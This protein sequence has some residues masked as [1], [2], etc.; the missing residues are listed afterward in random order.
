MLDFWFFVFPKEIQAW[1][2]RFRPAPATSLLPAVMIWGVAVWSLLVKNVAGKGRSMKRNFHEH[3]F[4]F[5]FHKIFIC[6]FHIAVRSTKGSNGTATSG[7]EWKWQWKMKNKYKM[8]VD[9]FPTFTSLFLS[10]L[11][12]FSSS[13]Q[14]SEENEKGKRK[15][16]KK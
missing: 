3:N 4:V 2:S 1:G 9:F 12:L 10:S 11:A 15:E 13:F 8:L 7:A 14:R 6:H 16:R 5:I